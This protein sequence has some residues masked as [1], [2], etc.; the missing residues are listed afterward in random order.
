MQRQPYAIGWGAVVERDLGCVED[1]GA[2]FN[3]GIALDNYAMTHNYRDVPS[4]GLL[5]DVEE[6]F[7]HGVRVTAAVD[8]GKVNPGF[9]K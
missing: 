1:H 8:V 4:V 5:R 7:A 9:R 2:E 3:P 6:Q